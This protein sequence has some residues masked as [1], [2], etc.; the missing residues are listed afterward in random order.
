MRMGKPIKKSRSW[1]KAGQKGKPKH[2]SPESVVGQISADLISTVFLPKIREM[3]TESLEFY[4]GELLLQQDYLAAEAAE[5]QL[6]SDGSMRVDLS[7]PIPP[8]RPLFHSQ[9]QIQEL[10]H[11]MTETSN[12]FFEKGG[13]WKVHANAAKFERML[14][15]KYGVFRPFIKNHPEV[16]VMI[17]SV[18][19]KYAMG[20]FSPLR[21]GEPPIPKHPSYCSL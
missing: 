4:A 8:K 2:A 10:S 7:M 6:G 21:Q 19:R 14:D 13:G 15:E 17:R 12:Y 20:N 3:A 5:A 16:E 11:T 9:F 1:K 18:Q